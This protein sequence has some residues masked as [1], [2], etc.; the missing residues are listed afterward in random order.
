MSADMNMDASSAQENSE[1]GQG[2]PPIQRTSIQEHEFGARSL[3]SEATEE[4]HVISTGNVNMVSTEARP[5]ECN[6]NGIERLRQP[7]EDQ[8]RNLSS[9]QL[10]Q[11]LEDATMNSNSEQFG[12]LPDH[13]AGKNLSALQ[14]MSEINYELV[15]ENVN[16][17][18]LVE[19]QKMGIGHIQNGPAETGTVE[20]D[21]LG[22]EQSILP[23]EDV[24]KNSSWDQLRPT[25]EDERKSSLEQLGLPPKDA[26][27]NTSLEQLKPP[28]DHGAGKKSSAAQARSEIN[29]ELV[30][31]NVNSEA[32]VE[33]KK[34]CTG[35]IQNVPVETEMVELDH[36]GLEQ[37]SLPSED[38]TKNSS[39]DQ[40]RSSPQDG[41]NSSLE[42]LGLPP[43]DAAVDTSPERLN[44][45][46]DHAAGKILSARQT[47]P[48]INREEVPENVNSEA[49]VETQNIGTGCIQNGPAETE[50]V[51]FDHLGLELCGLPSEDVTENSSRDQLRPP[52]E[53][54]RK[55]TLVQSELV[56]ENVDSEA[57]VET[58]KIGTGYI[59]NG[60]AETGM[61]EF[62][63]LGLELSG[64]TSENVT[65]NSGRDQLRLPPEDERKS[66]LEQSG[67]PPKDT[68]VNTSLEELKTP[69]DNTAGKILNAKQAM[70]EINHVLVPENVN[71]E[72]LVVTQKVGT[73]H[74]Q[75]EPT[76]TGMVEFDHLGLEQSDLPSED[77]TKSSSWEQL[78]PSPEDKRKSSMEQLGLPPEDAAVNANLEKLKPLP[79]HAAGKILSAKQAMPE[80][81]HV[82]VPE[83][84]NIEALVVTR[85]VCTGHIQNGP[86]ETGTVEF[87]HLGLQQSGLPSEDVTKSSSSEQLRPPLEDEKNSSMEQLGL[88]P[89]DAAVNTSLEQLE[90]LPDNVS[91]NCD[92]K[93]LEE[94]PED[95][96][97]NASKLGGRGRRKSTKSTKHAP[98]SS[99]MST[100]VL[101]SRLQ[102][103]PK[104]PEP[105]NNLP[106]HV[107]GANQEK[108]RKMRK[109]KNMKK[110]PVD[111]VSRIRKHLRYL[112]N[113]I[114]Y[115]QNLIDAYSGE[116]WKGQSLEKI[117]PEKELQRA[118][119]EIFRCKLKIRD[120][121]QRLDLLI[122]EGRLPESLFD[123]E[124]QIDSEDIFC[125]KCG[126][127]DL[128]ADNDII[129]CDG[130]CER[131]FHQFC[132][133]PPLLKED[134]PPDE[135]GW[136]CPG[137]DC[138]VDCI[139][140]LNDSQ[141]T[142]LSVL[143]TWEKVFPE[144][145][146]AAAAGN[147]LDSVGLPS[148]DSDDNDY[149]PDGSEVDEKVEGDESSF[150]ESDFYSA[151]E[152][153]GDS[154]KNKQKLEL[155]SD[156]S[157]D[158]D[159]DP[160]A[161]DLSDQVKQE[162]SSSDFTSDSE[163]F[164][165]A[166]DD[167]ISPC[168]D[169]PVPDELMSASSDQNKRC[170]VSNGERS[171]VGRRKKQS[172][173][174]ELSYL[175]ES[176][177]GQG[178]SA[179]LS[180]KRHVERLD[181]KSLHDETYGNVS[182]DSSDE[183][184][185]DASDVPTKRRK[186]NTGKVASASPGGRTPIIEGNHN[187]EENERTPKRRARKK[188]DVEGTND[189]PAKSYKGSSEPGSSYSGSKRTPYKRLGEA[190]TQGLLRAFKENQYPD[191]AAKENLAKELGITTH[192][193]S[194]WF[195]NARWS[196]RHTSRMASSLESVPMSEPEQKMVRE[197]DAGNGVKSK[198][199]SKV[200]A[201]LTSTTP[202]G[203]KRKS[204]PEHQASSD[205]I[206]S[207]E[208]TQNPS[209]PVDLPKSQEVRKRSRP[210]KARVQ[211]RGKPPRSQEVR[212]RGRPKRKKS[213]A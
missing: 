83:N 69:P 170:G 173:D 46:P 150:D 2:S 20:F 209:A 72:A 163:D 96:A 127:K 1:T 87:N 185:M 195:E 11:P 196:F 45:P 177:P 164:S 6:Y 54:K 64:L 93:Q 192:Q 165:V 52:P 206:L 167:N 140:L 146:A 112:L 145:A 74:I 158:D 118:K 39:W 94:Q 58:Q 63:H 176:G 70:P 97:N 203:H 138:K 53:D 136:L 141:G 41:R 194:K 189:S 47:M 76:E 19:T 38:V 102:E 34:I 7:H 135:K 14:A 55:F 18:A 148:D 4:K 90:P 149:D 101:R 67:L 124:G 128:G 179:P 68:A 166:F 161:P 61:A 103:K 123:S 125:A 51:E 27:V 202:R 24:T 35:R 208:E 157:E 81:N 73:G 190:V 22:F 89:E 120:L 169:E 117:K 193:I 85:K 36:L 205:H 100:R 17:E 153:N 91:N 111:E 44:S 130:A 56:P 152:D 28:P 57:L 23:S 88:P 10:G 191:R 143:D 119:S 43:K 75:G 201:G 33:T 178:E 105:S 162:S 210:P 60:P 26:A 126:S 147:K 5:A 65:E 156:D 80:I 183:N 131:G 129:L 62:N 175:L 155:P 25:P 66:T 77:M 110:I 181:Y 98:G 144:A 71:S 99:V 133:E 42:Q 132:L 78:C 106:E 122:A 187:Q 12:L 13:V 116:G 9:E 115:E 182:S 154:P 104:A 48:E 180:G 84:E 160:D 212:K 168:K 151:S 142:V 199:P 108:R 109:K 113:R 159:Y 79:D 211:K 32:L 29:H 114:N 16:C 107:D 137:C 21:H 59:Q 198:E 95:A 92:L 207:I 200:D 31:E 134:I 171:K 197:D 3:A 204:Q 213:A 37:S 86:T 188:L 186:N 121:F 15:T 50:T 184:W 139:D 49:L 40:L 30:P 174:D 172:L 82:L 8:T